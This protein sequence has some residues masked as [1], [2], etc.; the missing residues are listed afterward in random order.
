MTTS[1]DIGDKKRFSAAF[2]DINDAAADPTTVTVRIRE[3]DGT[4]TAYIY[5]TD[6]EVVK[7]AVGNYYVDVTFD[8]SGRHQVRWEGVGALV[9]AEQTEVYVRRTYA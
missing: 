7:S 6:V 4:V 9:T 5:G 2:T 1:Y 8:Q 3:P